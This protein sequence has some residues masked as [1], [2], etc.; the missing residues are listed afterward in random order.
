MDEIREQLAMMRT[1]QEQLLGEQAAANGSN[2]L[3][4]LVSSLTSTVIGLGLVAAVFWTVQNSREKAEAA[5]AV[6]FAQ[7]ERMQVTLASI[8]DGVIVCDHECKVTFLNPV[9]ESLTGWSDSDAAGKA[10]STVFNIVSEDTRSM[11]RSP[12]ARALRDG[13]LWVS[14]T[15]LADLQ[16]GN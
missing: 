13:K 4:R 15:I 1:A 2:I 11:S 8:G 12:A 10:L 5:A 6:L 16:T 14:Q 7:H 9:S 3:P